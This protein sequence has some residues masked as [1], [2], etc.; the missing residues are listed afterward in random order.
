MWVHMCI[1]SQECSLLL[2]V[3]TV[4]NKAFVDVTFPP[5][6]CHLLPLYIATVR[7][8]SHGLRLVMAGLQS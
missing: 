3:V 5:P 4:V 1:I 8:L 2:N 7:P 6:V